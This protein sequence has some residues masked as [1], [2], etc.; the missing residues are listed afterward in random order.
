MRKWVRVIF[1][2]LF[3]E[4]VVRHKLQ[5]EPHPAVYQTLQQTDRQTAVYWIL[6]T[7]KHGKDYGTSGRRDVAENGHFVVP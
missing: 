5:I 7:P 3:S 4:S 6:K 2:L 1:P